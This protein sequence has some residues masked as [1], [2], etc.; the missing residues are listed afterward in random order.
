MSMRFNVAVLSCLIQYT[1]VICFGIFY[2]GFLSVNLS[3]DPKGKKI[4]HNHKQLG[5][6]I[7]FLMHSF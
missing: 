4:Q 7:R 2:Q 1:F 5:N 3:E 6:K